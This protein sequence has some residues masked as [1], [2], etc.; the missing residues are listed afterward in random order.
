MRLN[1]M[2][3]TLESD[4]TANPQGQMGL[5]GRQGNMSTV[6]MGEM[7]G[8]SIV[9]AVQTLTPT[10]S[11]VGGSA[12]GNEMGTKDKYSPD[13]LA[14]LMGFAHINRV[15]EVP[16]FWKRVQAS[17]KSRGGCNRHVP[18]NNNRRYVHVGL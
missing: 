15:H 4:M 8:H 18:I 1:T 17:W 3:G 2:L 11:G 9:A 7:I 10:A 16:Q 5:G 6:D 12:T 13:K 14:A